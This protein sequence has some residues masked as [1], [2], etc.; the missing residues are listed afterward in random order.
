MR[1][2]FESERLVIAT[3]NAGKAR[4]I[5]ALLQPYVA[6]FF[7]AGDLDL[8]EPEET[9]DTFIGNAELKA[10][11]AARVSGMPALADDSGLAVNAL[12]GDPGIYSARWAEKEDG[13]RDFSYAMGRVKEAMGDIPD[14]SGAFICALTLAWPDGHVESFEG[15]V[16]GTLE[17]PPR[18]DHG[19][20]YDPI[21]VPDGYDVTFA[22]M[23]P[24]VKH[25]M[26][27]R[28]DAFRQMVAA[29]FNAE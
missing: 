15:R 4:E 2:R 22:E 28:A 13:S 27:H 16:N 23:E 7:T 24:S 26:S 10:L 18:G 5:S 11:A 25:D 14:R 1:R 12:G 9:E 6:Q 20:G 17:F 8:A 19:F 29:I 3:H 21:F